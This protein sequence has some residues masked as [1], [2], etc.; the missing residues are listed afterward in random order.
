MDVDFHNHSKPMQSK[1]IRLHYHILTP[2]LRGLIIWG[3]FFHEK[4]ANQGYNGGPE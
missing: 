3:C 4:G 2:L 1:G